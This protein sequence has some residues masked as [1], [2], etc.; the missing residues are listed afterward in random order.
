MPDQNDGRKMGRRAFVETASL[1][2]G[3][4]T[5]D[6]G[7]SGLDSDNAFRAA[8]PMTR[9]V[10][11]AGL[12]LPELKL[13]YRNELFGVLIPFWDKHGIDHQHGGFMC[14][15]DHD[16]TR[17]STDKFLWF[18]GR[19]MWVYT[20]LYTHFGRDPRHL[21]VAR[22]TKDF[23]LK[24][25][26]DESGEWA[27]LVAREGK[28][29]E[30]SKKDPSGALYMA[31]G[32]QAYARAAGDGEAWQVALETIRKQFRE[33]VQPLKAVPAEGTSR[34]GFWFLNLLVATQI[35]RHA[36]HSEIAEI[37]DR[38]IEAIIKHHYNPD[39]G[40]NNEVLNRNFS[41]P[42]RESTRTIIGHSIEALWMVMEEALRRGDRQLFTTCEKRLRRHLEVGWD[43]VYGG[44][45]HAV[46]I[47]QSGYVWPAERPV[48]TDLDFRFVGEYHYMKTLWSLYEVLLSCMKVL[49]HREAD[50]AVRYF[51]M[52]QEF[53]DT[54]L[55]LKK[56]GYPLHL[57]FTD[58]KA[59][60]QPHSSRQENYHN[61]RSL[62]FNLQALDRMIRR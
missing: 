32:L 58:R 12:S 6:A 43:W 47:D 7:E 38:S 9:P 25:F 45:V 8:R 24:Y 11:L 4:L 31:E 21:E 26:R 16:G 48:G 53:I 50:W 40:L 61:F 10:K 46:N 42:P 34:Q 3:T 30:Q 28:V 35:L 1:G 29:L 23:A 54:K 51:D 39:T 13:R 18:Q 17:V 22:K 14:A 56:Y 41:R 27:Q 15:L 60:Y 33:T 37:A 52:A 62:M 19:G 55:S 59:T 44:L 49:E 57:L 20:Y 5:A 2:I 36:H